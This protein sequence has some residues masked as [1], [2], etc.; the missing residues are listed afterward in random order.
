MLLAWPFIYQ[1][2]LRTEA[3]QDTALLLRRAHKMNLATLLLFR[4]VPEEV[5]I[6]VVERLDAN[7]FQATWQGGNARGRISG[8]L[9]IYEPIYSASELC[10]SLES[11]LTLIGGTHMAN[12]SGLARD[13][14]YT[15]TITA[16]NGVGLGP[17]GQPMIVPRKLC[18]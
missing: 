3:H 9:V 8:F 6:V 7:S 16:Y 5:E 12:F 14:A 13:L 2:G 10:R 4:T 15:V 17:T 11:N 1:C 18:M